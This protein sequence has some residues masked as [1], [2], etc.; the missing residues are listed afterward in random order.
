LHTSNWTWALH[1]YQESGVGALSAASD[2]ATN[3]G[4]GLLVVVVLLLAPRVSSIFRFDHELTPGKMGTPIRSYAFSYPTNTPRNIRFLAQML[5]VRGLDFK[6]PRRGGSCSSVWTDVH[7]PAPESLFVVAPVAP[8]DASLP[9]DR[10]WPDRSAPPPGWLMLVVYL[11]VKL[12]NHAIY[13]LPD[14][15]LPL[16]EPCLRTDVPTAELSSKREH[17]GSKP[18]S[19]AHTH[20][21]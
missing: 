7:S 5:R 9:L 4:C 13:H 8:V 19:V 1:V 20:P 17:C 10:T 16:A 15:T 14:S 21:Q 12:H 6:R 18:P 11:S 2:V 3:L